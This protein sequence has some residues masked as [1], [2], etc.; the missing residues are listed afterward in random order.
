[1]VFLPNMYTALHDFIDLGNVEN[2]VEYT[3][4]EFINLLH[5]GAYVALKQSR[6]TQKLNLAMSNALR[7]MH[8][9]KEIEL[10]RRLDS[11][12][13]W[14]LFP[15]PEHVFVSEISHVVVNKAVNR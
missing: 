2:G 4:E 9:N 1:M 14:Q 8:D 3:I 13:V 7:L 11:E 15:N 5:E 6:V 12:K 10:S